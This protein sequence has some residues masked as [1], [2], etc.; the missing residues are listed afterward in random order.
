MDL[1]IRNCSTRNPTATICRIRPIILHE[2][3]VFLVLLVVYLNSVGYTPVTGE[4]G[5][6]YLAL[7]TASYSSHIADHATDN[8]GPSAY[9][10]DP[11]KLLKEL[12]LSVLLVCWLYPGHD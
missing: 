9:Y 12:L 7:K 4:A 1:D 8:S 5:D 3:P 2:Y 10:V 6:G 11:H